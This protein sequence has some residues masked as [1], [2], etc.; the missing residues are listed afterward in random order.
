VI[1]CTSATASAF[2][3]ASCVV[4]MTMSVLTPAGAVRPVEFACRIGRSVLSLKVT[5]HV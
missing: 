4:L 2:A 3:T 5:V 1:R